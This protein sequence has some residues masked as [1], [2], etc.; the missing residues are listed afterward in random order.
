MPVPNEMIL[1]TARSVALPWGEPRRPGDS[2]AEVAQTW[3]TGRIS[4]AGTIRT[5]PNDMVGATM[6]PWLHERGNHAVE[7]KWV[8]MRVADVF[9]GLASG[10]SDGGDRRHDGCH[11]D[12]RNARWL[13]ND[14]LAVTGQKARSRLLTSL[15]KTPIMYIM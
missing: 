4:G 6:S 1:I 10:T 14:M 2:T 13:S 9:P 3:P 5:K 8:E 11:D 7:K 15:V 12:M